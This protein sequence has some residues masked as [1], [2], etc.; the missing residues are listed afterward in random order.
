MQGRHGHCD[1]SEASTLEQ[2]RGKFHAREER[3]NLY[4]D[5]DFWNGDAQSRDDVL[6]QRSVYAWGFGI[7]VWK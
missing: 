4:S 1:Y 6:R 3:T 7:T 2:W 5:D